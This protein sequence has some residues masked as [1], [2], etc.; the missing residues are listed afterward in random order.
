MKNED[1]F[2]KQIDKAILGRERA[3]DLHLPELVKE[4]DSILYELN[5]IHQ[6]DHIRMKG[7]DFISMQDFDEWF[8]ER[9][10]FYKND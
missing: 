3:E 2:K 7:I 8:K 1:F 10:R 5:H 4:I 9:I 6:F